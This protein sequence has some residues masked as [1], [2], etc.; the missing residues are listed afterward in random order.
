A[1]HAA[2]AGHFIVMHFHPALVAFVGEG[3]GDLVALDL[4]MAIVG[5]AGAQ[6]DALGTGKGLF[7]FTAQFDALAQQRHRGHRAVLMVVIVVMAA[8]V[9][10]M[11]VTATVQRAAMGMAVL[12]L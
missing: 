12:V 2:P 5:A 9:V 6:A 4:V 7:Q 1:D 3:G 8:V 11:V 10:I